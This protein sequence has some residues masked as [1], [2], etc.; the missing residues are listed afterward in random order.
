MDRSE[1]DI[2][3]P[4][5]KKLS[6][7]NSIKNNILKLL[8]ILFIGFLIFSI[9]NLTNTLNNIGLQELNKNMEN[10]S[11]QL[12]KLNEV[13]EELREL[14]NNFGKINMTLLINTVSSISNN[15]VVLQSL[16]KN[17]IIMSGNYYNKES[18]T[19]SNLENP[20]NQNYDD[21]TGFYNGKIEFSP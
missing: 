15:I 13:N 18:D 8:L 12:S 11:Y 14:N 3:N 5:P 7:I 6:L 16:L 21:I 1:H 9:Y 19:N 17:P 2:N 10:I 20:S 4:Q